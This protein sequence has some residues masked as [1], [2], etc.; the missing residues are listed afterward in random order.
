ME[1]SSQ[2]DPNII[3]NTDTSDN[4]TTTTNP[5]DDK[6]IIVTFTTPTVLASRYCANLIEADN[7]KNIVQQ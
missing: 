5:A 1:N 2:N 3:E 4:Y 7:D 6:Q